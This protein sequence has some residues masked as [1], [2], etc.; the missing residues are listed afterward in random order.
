[1]GWLALPS[2]DRLSRPQ[3]EAWRPQAPPKGLPQIWAV[4]GAIWGLGGHP[5]TVRDESWGRASRSPGGK[6]YHI[7]K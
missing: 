2:S 6:L 1:M 4:P 3:N 7:T 5:R